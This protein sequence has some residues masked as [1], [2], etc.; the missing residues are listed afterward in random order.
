MDYNTFLIENYQKLGRKKCAEILSF[1]EAKIFYLAKKLNLVK[2]RNKVLFDSSIFT[3]KESLTKESAYLLGFLWA[4]GSLLNNNIRLGIIEEDG[5]KIE[6]I[7]YATG[8]WKVYRR[9]RKN[10]KPQIDYYICDKNFS[11]FL[12]EHGK[13]PNTIES[14]EK[15]LKFIGDDY[16]LYFLR[17]LIDGDGCFSINFNNNRHYCQL[18]ISGRYEQD[19]SFLKEKIETFFNVKFSIYKQQ[20]KLKN[21]KINHSSCI[22][23][24]SVN[25]I[26]KIVEILYKEND[27]IFLQRKYDKVNII[28]EHKNKIKKYIR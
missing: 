9:I 18:I 12:R 13:Y 8:N 2:H 21:G 22:R 19:W 25:D 5:K 11:S 28:K 1:S 23:C 16:F 4:D 7:I 14:H 3:N 6:H 26:I 17:G 27:G 10:R 24:S 15:I 20:Y